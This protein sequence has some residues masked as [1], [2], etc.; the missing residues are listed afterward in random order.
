MW[1][2]TSGTCFPP[3]ATSCCVNAL[4]GRTRPL[5]GR[6]SEAR[7]GL[8]KREI[9][10]LLI[11]GKQS[12]GGDLPGKHVGIG[13]LITTHTRLEEEGVELR[14]IVSPRLKALLELSGLTDLLQPEDP[15]AS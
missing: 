6:R 1:R 12:E 7:P 9:G 10:D 13:L 2:G 3:I 8:D 11:V 5:P 4:P 14:L 15:T